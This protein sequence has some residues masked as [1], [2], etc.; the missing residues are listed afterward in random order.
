MT[1]QRE[2]QVDDRRSV[3]IVTTVRILDGFDRAKVQVDL[4][5]LA[6][7]DATTVERLLVGVPHVVK[8]NIDVSTAETYVRRLRAI[9]V[10]CNPEPEF[11]D[12]EPQPLAQSRPTADQTRSS[13]AAA[14][15]QTDKKAGH[16][17]GFSCNDRSSGH[18]A[19]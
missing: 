3:R 9:G 8:H 4:A 13:A 19:A 7:Q 16:V 1:R 15:K 6:G 10:E 14:R 12:L 11:L 5:K 2:E 17:P 18:Y